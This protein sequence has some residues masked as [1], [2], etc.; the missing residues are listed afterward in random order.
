MRKL[1]RKQEILQILNEGR[2]PNHSFTESE[3]EE[4]DFGRGAFERELTDDDDEQSLSAIAKE[5]AN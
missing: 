1:E 2:D 3:S 4:E 5:Y